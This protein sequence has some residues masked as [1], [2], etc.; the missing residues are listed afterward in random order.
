MTMREWAENEIRL[1]C[2]RENPNWDGKS[3]DYGCSCYQSALKAYESLLDDGHS[4]FSFGLTKN[5]LIRLME[6][7]PLSPIEDSDFDECPELEWKKDGIKSHKQCFRRSSLFR[8]ETLDGRV[9]Y[10]DNDRVSFHDANGDGWW[11]NRKATDIVDSMFPIA[12]PYTP[13]K[14]CFEVYGETFYMENGIDKSSEHVGEY[15][16]IKMYYIITPTG[17]RIELNRKFDA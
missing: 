4:G 17:E 6:S 14:K 16:L 5:I 2:K 15:N 10:H 8:E 9:F 12:M 3:F 7:L 13:S 11:H 1:A